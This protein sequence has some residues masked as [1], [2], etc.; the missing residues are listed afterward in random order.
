VI[1]DSSHKPWILAATSALLTGALSYAIYIA[2]SDLRPSGGSGPGLIY[3]VAGSAMI[4]LSIL[5]SAR[6][7]VPTMRIG[8]VHTWMKAHVWLGLLSFPLILFHSGFALGGPLTT[9]LMVLFTFIT[10]SGIVGVLLQQFIPKLMMDQ[11]PAEAIY[12]QA[13]ETLAAIRTA[14]EERVESLAPKG[15]PAPDYHA[16]KEFFEKAIIPFLEDRNASRGLLSSAQKAGA[17]FTSLRKT[18]QPSSYAV[19]E[20]LEEL[21]EQR[22]QLQLQLRLHHVLHGWLLVHVPLSWALL[23]LV[24]LH[25]VMALRY[26]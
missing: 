19:L 10:L 22:R 20:D 24:I 18:V 7:K 23:L 5:L 12:E 21:V 3:G 8:R 25:A 9:V 2:V 6:K 15:E 11:L 17:V 13:N 4:G 1:I 16:V 26:A 14:V